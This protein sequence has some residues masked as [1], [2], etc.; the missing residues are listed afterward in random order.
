MAID[1]LPTNAILRYG[2]TYQ[3]RRALLLSQHRDRC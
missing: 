3:T 2:I 1:E